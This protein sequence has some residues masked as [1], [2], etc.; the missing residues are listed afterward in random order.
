MSIEENLKSL[1]R[2]IEEAASACGRRPED[3]ILV[4]ACKMNDRDRVRRAVAAG[5]RV[6]GENRV[7]EM[8]EKSAQGAYEGAELHFIG[9]LQRNKVRQTVGLAGLIQ[10]VHSLELLSAIDRAAREKGVCQAVLLEV[11]VAGELSKSGFAPAEIPAALE[12][13]AGL[14]A[15]KVR[16]LMAI[17]PISAS[18]AENRP[19]FLR[20][21]QLFVDNEEKKYDNVS[22]DFLSMGMS[23]DYAEAIACGAN[24]V[25]VGSGIF[26]PRSYHR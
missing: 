13:C 21:K 20:M 11:N 17:P 2:G 3:V 9:H 12:F 22:M 8:L 26:G 19:Y 5:V 1:R 23:G 14:E 15:V 25:R 18:P 6:C 7:Q 24:M 16:G 10:S 4:A